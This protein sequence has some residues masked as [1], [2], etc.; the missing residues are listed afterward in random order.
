MTAALIT[1]WRLIAAVALAGLAAG[2]AWAA[3]DEPIYSATATVVPS[4]AAVDAGAKVDDLSAYAE[5]GMG[6]E[7]ADRTAALLGDDVPGAD[8]LS[9]VTVTVPAEEGVLDI[10]ATSD[11]PDFAAAAADAYAQALVDVT[12]D[13]S[14]QAL[15]RAGERLEERLGDLGEGSAEAL[16]L[17]ER[18]DKLEQRRGAGGPLGVGAQAVLPDSPSVDRPAVLWAL[19][20]LLV[21][22][23]LA[24]AGVLLAGRPRPSPDGGSGSVPTVASSGEGAA[25]EPPRSEPV[26]AARIP[27]S[28]D[29]EEARSYEALYGSP[30][31]ARELE[32]LASA[33][34]EPE[35]REEESDAPEGE[36]VDPVAQ[37]PRTE[38]H[39]IFFDEAEDEA[40]SFF[41]G[42]EPEDVDPDEVEADDAAPD[43]IEPVVA[44]PEVEAE[45]EIEVDDL[46]VDEPGPEV[47]EPDIEPTAVAALAALIGTATIETMPGLR[48]AVHGSGPALGVL[49]ADEMSGY[50][51]LVDEL[52]LDAEEAPGTVGVL[53]PTAEDGAADAAL[54]LAAAAAELGLRVILIEAD[55]QRPRLATELEVDPSPG[56]AEYLAGSAGPRDV[57]RSLRLETHGGGA[58]PM[59]CVPAGAGAGGSLS[60][61]RFEALVERLPRAYDLAIFS[62]PPLLSGD[63]GL[64]VADEVQ[65]TVLATRETE[66]FQGRVGR[67]VELLEP[68]AVAGAV[69][70]EASTP[71]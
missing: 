24:A 71:A 56:L 14:K 45:T 43:V 55:L 26:A 4:P 67:S 21:G 58:F 44:E 37:I 3:S 57:L 46:E 29:P 1:R 66:G 54:G 34:K 11:M 23:L 59:V 40:E 9:Q 33:E 48:P 12:S 16:D 17:S 70:I 39:R 27:R 31:P 5:I 8:L 49:D 18:I 53:A 19:G 15:K 32:H 6:S 68:L 69:L 41:D 20:G 30:A 64:A 38:E 28:A 13:D 47:D 51:H 50:R 63:E 25:V 52:E 22:A 36:E 65:A 35:P 61:D 7:V 62:A 2:L 42:E 10:E 60:S